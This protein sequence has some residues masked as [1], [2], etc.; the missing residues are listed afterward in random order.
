[1][2]INKLMDIWLEKTGVNWELTDSTQELDEIFAL[3][4]SRMPQPKTMNEATAR[5]SMLRETKQAILDWHTREL[6]EAI[7]EEWAL[8]GEDHEVRTLIEEG[9]S[10]RTKKLL[11]KEKND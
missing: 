3:L 1:M 8:I 4:D 2:D 10:P 5:V 6:N 9:V 11:R 7:R